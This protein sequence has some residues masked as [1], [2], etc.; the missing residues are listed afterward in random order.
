MKKSVESRGGTE[1]G[2]K[3]KKS[4]VKTMLE[5]VGQN[6]NIENVLFID[7]EEDKIQKVSELGVNVLPVD[8]DYYKLLDWW[9]PTMMAPNNVAQ[10][11]QILGV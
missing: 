2:L 1:F 3:D 5:I 11:R 10:T 4:E 7:D 8:T 6:N 9:S